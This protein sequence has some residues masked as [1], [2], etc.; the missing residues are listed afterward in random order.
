M[1]VLGRGRGEWRGV[2]RDWASMAIGRGGRGKSA[3]NVSW[4]ENDTAWATMCCAVPRTV[5]P[6]PAEDGH[7]HAGLEA[8][9]LG[10]R[11]VACPPER[12]GKR[13]LLRPSLTIPCLGVMFEVRFR[14][15]NGCSSLVQGFVDT[16]ATLIEK[17]LGQNCLQ[18]LVVGSRYDTLRRAMICMLRC[19][20]YRVVLRAPTTCLWFRRPSH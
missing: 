15:A 8:C 3:E 12:L 1:E 4:L 17:L 5:T 20:P 16:V 13:R 14:I 7:S 19:P 18:D 2:V 11:S 10:A 6:A 9:R